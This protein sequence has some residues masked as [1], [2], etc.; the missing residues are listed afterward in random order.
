[1][2]PWNRNYHLHHHHH[3]HHCHHHHHHHRHHHHH[4]HRHHIHHHHCH[5]LFYFI[6]P[7]RAAGGGGGGYSPQML[8]GMCRGKVKTKKA[9]APETSLSLFELENEG[10][11]NELEP[12]WAWKSYSPELP[13]RVW[14]WR[15]GRLLTRGA[16]ER[17]AFGNDSLQNG[18][19]RQKCKMV[20]LRN[21]FWKWW[22]PER[23]TPPPKM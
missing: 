7:G 20:M 10:L 8:V 18:K 1:M 14:R 4:H 22:S 12:F 9:R 16:A 23:Q 19:L 11:R 13:G 3:R 15:S 17:F 5:H 6:R 21:G 2:G